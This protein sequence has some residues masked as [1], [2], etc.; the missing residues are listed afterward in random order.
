MKIKALKN[1]EKESFK[2]L[3]DLIHES[4]MKFD[5]KFKSLSFH[6]FKIEFKNYS[7]EQ[8]DLFTEIQITDAFGFKFKYVYTKKVML[9]ILEFL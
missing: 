7:N 2:V 8:L 4:G 3:L 9:N 5:N 6:D 1:I